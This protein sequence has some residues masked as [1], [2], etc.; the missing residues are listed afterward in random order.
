M[1]DE[2]RA[3]LAL[4]PLPTEEGA[5]PANVAR[6]ECALKAVARPVSDEEARGLVKVF[7]GDDCFGL[8]W[9]LLHLIETAPNWP[10]QE[11][12][13]QAHPTWAEELRRRCGDDAVR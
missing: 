12:I 9:S 4:G 2:V 3:L 7:G 1:R 10:L 11:A 8:A 5:V 6:Y 13:R